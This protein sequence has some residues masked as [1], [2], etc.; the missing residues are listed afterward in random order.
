MASPHVA[1]AAALF[2]AANSN[3]TPAEVKSN[4]LSLASTNKVS[5]IGPGSTNLLLYSLVDG[6]DPLPTPAPTNTPAP[7]PTATPLPGTIIFFD[8][9]ESDKGWET[10]PAGNDTATTG[11]WQRGSPESTSID[12]VTMQLGESYSGSRS[13][14]T[15]PLAGDQAGVFDVDDGVTSIESPTI[16]LPNSG[17]FTLHYAYYLAH[18][19]NSANNDYLTIEVV[20]S[21]STTVL[22]EQGANNLDGGAWETGSAD[23]SQFAGQT[24][25]ILISAADNGDPSLIEAGIDDV[26]ITQE[27][28]TGPQPTPTPDPPTPTPEPGGPPPG[29]IIFEDDFETDTGWQL[30]PLAIDTASSGQWEIAN[31]QGTEDNGPKQLG[32]AVSGQNTLVTGPLA[33]SDAGTH[34]VDDGFT[35]MGSPL[36]GLPE[37]GPIT[38][39]FSYYFAHGSNATSDDTFELIIFDF[40]DNIE[41]LPILVETGS[42]VNLS[43]IH[44]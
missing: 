29:D 31:P 40:D 4:L 43:L 1:G 23:I 13:L 15:G 16:T 10:N 24:I 14:S 21:S 20:G 18:Y 5:D 32:N 38:L 8:D 19:N 27:N 12:G 39:S 2:L 28:G 41:T 22:N 35:T 25:T 11:F 9:F 36:I 6:N 34:D 26:F 7:L 17:T 37:S 33:G 3:A 30:D 42:P 44:I